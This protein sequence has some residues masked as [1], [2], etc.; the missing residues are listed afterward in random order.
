MR[1]HPK[2]TG[3]FINLELPCFQELCFF[4]RYRHL[5]EGHAFLQDGHIM[6]VFARKLRMPAFS[7]MSRIL[8]H[9]WMLQHTAWCCS[10]G[11]EGRAIGFC[12]QSHANCIFC[13]GNRAVADKAI[14]G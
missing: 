11:K 2:D 6:A 7:E 10:I 4:W 9:A 5:M 1:R 12:S 3:N 13:H 8:Y 14:K